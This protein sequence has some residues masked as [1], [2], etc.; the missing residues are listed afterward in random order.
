MRQ[1][2]RSRVATH[3]RTGPAGRM[4]GGGGVVGAFAL[5]LGVIL[6]VELPDKTLVATVVLATRFRR[7][8]PV[9]VGVGT[10][11][12]VQCAVACIAGGL[13]RILPHRVPE[14]AAAALFALGA[15]LLIRE[16]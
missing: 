14:I 6:L 12:A 3:L 16:V 8:W 11:F 4:V 5:A 9:M 15:V 13:L 7:P 10:A 2:P 1:E